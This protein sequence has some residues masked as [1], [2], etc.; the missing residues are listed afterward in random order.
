MK[1][2][3]GQHVVSQVAADWAIEDEP[4]KRLERSE[5]QTLKHALGGDENEQKLFCIDI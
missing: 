4:E 5:A 3:E 2:N 1:A